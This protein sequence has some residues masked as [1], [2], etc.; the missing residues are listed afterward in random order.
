M[1]QVAR[2]AS[3]D[4]EAAR[5]GG[6]G[7]VV[8]YSG[9][10]EGLAGCV[11]QKRFIANMRR[12]SSQCDVTHTILLIGR[13]S[14]RPILKGRDHVS[15]SH[16]SRRLTV[17]LALGCLVMAGSAPGAA[18]DEIPGSDD[19]V[20]VVTADNIDPVI[21]GNGDVS[22]QSSVVTQTVDLESGTL[23]IEPDGALE[24]VSIH[25]PVVADGD[26]V[27][28]PDGTL[29]LDST[30]DDGGVYVQALHGGG[31]RTLTTIENESAPTVFRY[32]ISLG[33]RQ[34]LVKA[35][36][37]SIILAEEGTDGVVS[38]VFTAQRP[39]ARDANGA[40]VPT[41]YEIEGTSI[42]Q[43]VDVSGAALPVVAD[44]TWTRRGVTV[45][46]PGGLGAA[47][48]AYLNKSWTA[49]YVTGSNTVC[50]IV[51]ALLALGTGIGGAVMGVACALHAGVY[52]VTTNHG[53]CAALDY[54]PANATISTKIVAR[55]YRNGYCR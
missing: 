48:T 5:V 27:K 12:T 16:T 8:G 31:I 45:T 14:G 15:Q 7:V 38:E 23:Q 39:W 26:P 29:R 9:L 30:V 3:A 10:V 22:V 42:V 51:T 40:S 28:L 37:G 43:H 17:A 6:L 19:L 18:A 21:D 46:V 52:S 47:A 36:D 49:D 34:S 2:G 55:P 25:L 20:Q 1:T 41:W 32:D 33:E 44:P 13:L 35:S 53:A 54:R 4:P 24:G 50:A 11:M